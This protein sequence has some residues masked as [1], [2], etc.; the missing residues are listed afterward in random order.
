MSLLTLLLYGRYLSD[1]LSGVLGVRAEDVL[2]LARRGRDPLDPPEILAR[3]L[4]RRANI[5]E[6]PIQYFG[7]PPSRESS[8]PL[9]S[10]LRALVAL[11]SRRWSGSGGRE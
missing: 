6:T 11:L 1:T 5:L 4:R 9:R 7:R 8:R 10:G 3:L 2:E